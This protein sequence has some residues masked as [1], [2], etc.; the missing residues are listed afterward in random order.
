MSPDSAEGMALWPFGRK[1][2]K[3]NNQEETKMSVA[4]A[5]TTDAARADPAR[6][7]ADL[8]PS[9]LSRKPSRK[10]SQRRTRS[11]SRV[12]TKS[13]PSM[14]AEL[15]KMEALP[16]V[17]SVPRAATHGPEQFD[18][19][20]SIPAHPGANRLPLTEVPANREDIPSYYFQNALS[21]SS[22]QPEKFA[23]E[24]SIPT[25]KARRGTVDASIPRRKS[26][27]RKAEDHAREREVR[28]LSSPIPIPKRPQS[29]AGGLLARESKR[30]PGGLNR[31]FERPTSE[32]SLPVPD[33]M[34]SSKSDPPDMH[35]FKISALDALSPR[36]TIKY[37]ENPRFA[38]NSSSLNPSRTS[39]RKDKRPSIAEEGFNSKERINDLAD[40]FDAGDL[41]EVME[42]DRRRREKKRKS[43]HE[44][45]QRRL[46][47]RSEKQRVEAAVKQLTPEESTKQRVEALGLGI[48]G[49][50][51]IEADRQLLETDRDPARSPASWFEDASRENEPIENPFGDPT[52]ETR[53][54]PA[55]P[56]ERDEPIIE[57][58]KAI[59]LSA[60]NVSTPSSPTRGHA[61]GP[62]N[63]STLN[64]LASRSNPDIQEKVQP[65]HV[66]RGSDT[67]ARLASSWTSFFRRSG[68]R[69]KRNSADRGREPPSE[70]SNTSRD[71]LA[72]QIPPPA[73]VRNAKERSG[74]PV[75]T[76]SKFREDLP[77]LPIS[78]PMSRVQS[79]DLVPGSSPYI[80]HVSKISELAAN[81]TAAEPRLS[82][83]H[84]AYREEIASLRGPSP[85]NPS[86]AILSQ[87]LASVDSE[88][89][90]LSGRPPKRS[91][92][93][94]NPMR[95]SGGSI[96]QNLLEEETAETG[97]PSFTRQT[98]SP[99]KAYVPGGIST[100]LHP[101]NVSTAEESDVE[102]GAVSPE[103]PVKVNAVV[104]RHPTIVRRNLRAKS[105]EGLLEDF[106]TLD[107][108]P[109]SSPS[110]YSPD[111]TPSQFRE[112]PAAGSSIHRATSVDLGKSG[113]AR[114]ISA[115]SARL[116]DLP[117]RS[118]GEMKRLSSGSLERSPLGSPLRATHENTENES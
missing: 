41:R 106:Q 53:L 75:R 100:Q 111:D 83:V 79:P 17:P 9:K 54:E 99:R 51:R 66:R 43:D 85:E 33:S 65:D 109:G 50:S 94:I 87:S 13:P 6:T 42:R 91:S 59:R 19:K 103:E 44:K 77:E 89:S 102:S 30:I 23:A 81:T 82:D 8:N 57:T 48:V 1:K 70:F 114:H 107:D 112:A 39:T 52:T 36:P 101:R 108:S 4:K 38:A 115:G 84:P 68:T 49:G 117:P 28:A 78:P 113:H 14:T 37:S 22:I 32:I 18:E 35:A 60:A 25:L 26:S 92:Q 73:L 72:R 76:Q 64:D 71:S 86:D 98:P 116:L 45:L 5:R 27:K 11:K 15:E 95:S 90:W 61:R 80:D 97:S 47:R 46:Q 93:Q 55:T 88:G 34:H 110:A 96:S 24:P 2:R 29:N 105:R 67:S 63:L 58:A 20:M 3:I 104:G 40:E 10:G 7:V 118:S 16:P 74:T 69:G 12:L 56:D 31:N 21:Q 62:S